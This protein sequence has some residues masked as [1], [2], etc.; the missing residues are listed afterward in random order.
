[1]NLRQRIDSLPLR[2]KLVAVIFIVSAT[3]NVLSFGAYLIYNLATLRERLED[4]SQLIA[5]TL[6]GYSAA[7]LA[8]R[9][10]VAGRQTLAGVETVPFIANAILYDLNGRVFTQ[11]RDNPAPALPPLVGTASA[12]FYSDYLHVIEP[13]RFESK[14]H[15]TLYLL[16]SLELVAQRMKGALIT[17]ALGLLTTLVLSFFL[18][19]W[20]QRLVSE[21]IRELADAARRVSYEADYSQRVTVHSGDELGTLTRAFNFML[22]RIAQR[23]AERDRAEEEIRRLNAQLEMK[24]EDRTAQLAAANKELEAFSY[25]VSH[26]LRAPLRAIHGFSA[27]LIEDCGTVLSGQCHA[28]LNRIQSASEKMGHLIDDMLQLSR[29]SRAEIQWA[30]VDLTTLAHDIVATLQ[31]HD[32]GRQ[33][34]ISVPTQ[35]P[36]QGDPRLLAIA[37]ENLIGNAWKFTR[38]QSAAT[39]EIGRIEQNNQPVYF[40]RDNGAGFNM[41]YADKLFKAFQRLHTDQQFEGTGVGLSIVQRIIQ[42]HGGSV[43]AESEEGKGATFYF[44]LGSMQHEIIPDSP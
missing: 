1:M 44:T 24:V 7:D 11:L 25:S 33:V 26:D 22:D 10:A 40:I 32:S 37:L 2:H 4:E 30:S 39:I 29:I 43:W 16:V 21:P 8:F 9:D 12:R 6:A 14:D 20:L 18:A 28:Y 15:G 3:V 19:L 38:H 31:Q 35:M 13:V 34:S 17:L 27:A 42:R 41:A 5:K 23:R 36:V